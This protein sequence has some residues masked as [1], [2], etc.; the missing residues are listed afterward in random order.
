M[1]L[2][3]YFYVTGGYKQVHLEDEAPADGGVLTT[4]VKPGRPRSRRGLSASPCRRRR[5][6][7]EIPA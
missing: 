2:I 1:I 3:L 4:D 7:S 5:V 6:A